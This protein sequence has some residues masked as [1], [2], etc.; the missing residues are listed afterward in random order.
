[1]IA[2]LAIALLACA[3]LAYVAG[4]ARAAPGRWPDLR[5]SVEDDLEEKKMAA[6]GAI[7][8]IEDERS[9]GKLSDEDFEILRRE[10]ESEALNALIELDGLQSLPD[11]DSLEAEIAAMRA[12][13]ACPNCGAPRSSAGSCERC[14]A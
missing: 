11:D 2:D 12:R 13:I 5:H 3:A 7:V 6:L 8:D 9:V 1:M 10:Y 14:G 4:G